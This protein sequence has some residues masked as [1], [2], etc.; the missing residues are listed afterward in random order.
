[1]QNTIT[2]ELI[3]GNFSS[4]REPE[5]IEEILKVGVLENLPEGQSLM[6]V[7]RYIKSVPLL[8]K[9]SVRVMREDQ[10][11]K[12]L[13]LYYLKPGETCA[14]SLTC[15]MASERSSIRAVVDEDSELIRIP[16]EYLDIWTKKYTSFKN[17]VMNTYRT[18]Y[19]ELLDT[20][21]SI[22]FMKMDER[23]WKF[24]I[25]RKSMLGQ[26][27]LNLTHQEIADSLHSTRE[28]ISRLLKALERDGKIELGRNRIKILEEF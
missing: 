2:E 10:D 21:D 12:E 11:G 18:R 14:V 20:I 26:E 25:E 16:V 23:L 9:G 24:L 3:K 27:E 19:E 13:F 4:F 6:E 1:M 5:L 28:V 15:C 17:F 7:G 8:T 22:A